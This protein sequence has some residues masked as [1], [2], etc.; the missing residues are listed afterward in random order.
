[1][2]RNLSRMLLFVANLAAKMYVPIDR[3][4]VRRLRCT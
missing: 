1:M 4:G 2:T 3:R